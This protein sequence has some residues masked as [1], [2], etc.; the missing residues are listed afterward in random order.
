MTSALVMLVTEFS[1]FLFEHY[2]LDWLPF[3]SA[4]YGKPL[5]YLVCGTF[6]FDPQIYDSDSDVPNH[7]AGFAL[8]T[9]GLLQIFFYMKTVEASP[10]DYRGF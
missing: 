1:P 4:R 5:L 6:C 10:S 8:L 2:L 3:L 7:Y 9:S